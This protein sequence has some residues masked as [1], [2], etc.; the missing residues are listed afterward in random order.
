MEQPLYRQHGQELNSNH[1]INDEA[2]SPHRSAQKER[3]IRC[4]DFFCPA[5][6]LSVELERGSGKCVW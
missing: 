5:Q 1:A 3:R 2:N 4:P 6:R